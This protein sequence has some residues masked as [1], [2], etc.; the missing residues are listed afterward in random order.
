MLKHTFYLEALCANII[1]LASPLNELNLDRL[2]PNIMKKTT[3]YE[4]LGISP[5][6]SAEE[7]KAAAQ[8][9]AQKYHPSK[10]PGNTRVA[11]RFKQIKIVYNILANPEK[12]AAYDTTLG[13]SPAAPSQPEETTEETLIEQLTQ[14]AHT[15]KTTKAK[16]KA[17]GDKDLLVGEKLIYRARI[18][19]FGYLKAVLIISIASYLLFIEPPL[20]LKAYMDKVDF[21]RNKFDYVNIA[22]WLL[23]VIGGWQLLQTLWKQLTTKVIITSQRTLA[24]QGLWDQRETEIA[25]NKFEHLE[26]KRGFIGIV[27]GF[28][29]IKMRGTRG[30][31]V[32]GL[33]II[34]QQLAAP[35]RFEKELMRAIRRNTTNQT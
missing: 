28:G 6:A 10:Y 13:L 19:W 21:L 33:N 11:K 18:H 7:I 30:R 26:I 23:L 2:T 34:V 20:F 35:T 15:E 27:F 12:R 3:Y 17:K 8:K 4:F 24:C 25:H 22:L 16:E 9:L 1:L 31:G 14:T 29:Q 32:G 5:Q